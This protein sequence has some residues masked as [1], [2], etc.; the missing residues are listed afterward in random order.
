MDVLTMHISTRQAVDRI[1]S[2]RASSLEP[3]EIDLEL[4]KA[5][6]RFINQ[7]YG[8]NNVYQEGFEESQ[9]R[10]DDLRTL[11]KEYSDTVTFKEILRTDEI[12]V[13]TFRLPSDYMYLVNQRSTIYINRCRPVPYNLETE[14]V[15]L[16]VFQPSN[17]LV[18]GGQFVDSIRVQNANWLVLPTT[19]AQVWQPSPE[20][21][22]SGYTSS[23]YPQYT[24]E[25]IDDIIANVAPGF[26]AYWET[27]GDL[28]LPGRI[29]IVA[30]LDT[31]PWLS[32]DASLPVVPTPLVGMQS[33]SQVTFDLP[34]PGQRLLE[35]RI[36]REPTDKKTVLNRFSQQDDIFRLLDDPFNTTNEKEPLTTMRDK[37][38][39]IYT[40]AIFITDSIKITYLRKPQSI[41]LS[42]GY[43]CDLPEHTHQEI[44]AMAV[45]SI[46]EEITDPRYK[47]Q[48]GELLNRE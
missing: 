12:W 17:L 7:R 5:L 26:T 31:F 4:N 9:K 3:E 19:E 11:L 13:D 40:S 16:Y 30:D 34:F 42:L 1:N 41:S 38:I 14:S 10:I 2:Q 21:I 8:K 36:P 32:W 48:M 45:S 23:G 43:D 6:Q 20:L 29:I 39:D 27:Y 25:V 44:V 46:L 15:I 24:Q 22:A 35:R 18:N 47:T 28:N 33:T 37:N